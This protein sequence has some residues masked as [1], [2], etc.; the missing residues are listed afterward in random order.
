MSTSTK[1]YLIVSAIAL[2]AAG[3]AFASEGPDD[4]TKNFVSTKSR[5]EVLAD[6]NIAYTAGLIESGEVSFVPVAKLS[7]PRAQ[8]VAEARE[9][10]RLG[11]TRSNEAGAPVATVAQNEAIRAAGAR[12]VATVTANVR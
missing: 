8:V 1:T 7:L 2:A 4:F 6:A 5:A 9:A 11:L 12:A 3:S 10:Q